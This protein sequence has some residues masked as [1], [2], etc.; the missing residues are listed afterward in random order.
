MISICIPS[1]L[2]KPEREKYLDITLD[3]VRK[4]FL[5]AFPEAEVS[6]VFGKFGKEIPGVK[7][8]TH[9]DVRGFGYSLNSNIQKAK[10]EWV[11]QMEDDRPFRMDQVGSPE[12]LRSCILNYIEVLKEYGGIYYLGN[13]DTEIHTWY[14]AGQRTRVLP[15]GFMFF[16]LNRPLKEPKWRQDFSMYYYSNLPH[17]KHRSLQEEV[18]WYDEGPPPPRVE[19]NMCKT[20]YESGR[21]VFFSKIDMFAHIGHVQATPRL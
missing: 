19:E 9:D 14:I 11:V 17:L 2:N 5:V 21:R 3:S 20:Y 6:V 18:G 10:Y 16:E 7:C 15:S 8:H 13:R 4:S 12:V 1:C